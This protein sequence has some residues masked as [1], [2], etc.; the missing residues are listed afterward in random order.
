MAIYRLRFDVV[1]MC[2]E[3]TL[4]TNREDSQPTES[5]TYRYRETRLNVVITENIDLYIKHEYGGMRVKSTVCC[6]P[7]QN[8]NSKE[9]ANHMKWLIQR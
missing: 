5:M 1:R 7:R 2:D 3:N 6:M 4:G 8:R 9:T